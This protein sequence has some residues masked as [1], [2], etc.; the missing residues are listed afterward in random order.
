MGECSYI[1]RGGR[2]TLG[3][4]FQVGGN[5]SLRYRV[6]KRENV[7]KQCSFGT[8]SRNSDGLHVSQQRNFGL[9]FFYMRN[10]S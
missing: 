1:N 8:L 9:K 10:Q 2:V 3:L 7:L 6:M 4:S 5:V